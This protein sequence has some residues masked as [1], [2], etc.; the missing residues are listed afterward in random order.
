MV[1]P[2]HSCCDALGSAIARLVVVGVLQGGAAEELL[3]LIGSVEV[4][5][6][7][8][9]GGEELLGFFTDGGCQGV[10]GAFLTAGCDF[11]GKEG[12]IYLVKSG[13]CGV[14]LWCCG[15]AGVF[16]LVLAL[17]LFLLALL[18]GIGHW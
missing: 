4:C 16:A 3:H 15:V 11:E 1:T 13:V 7:Y 17:L 12:L 18:G 5:G 9:E 2:I 8:A 10:V 6:V 14:S